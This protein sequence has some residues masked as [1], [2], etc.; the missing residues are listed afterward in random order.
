MKS[1]MDRD[2]YARIE[3]MYWRD[4][5]RHGVVLINVFMESSDA[6]ALIDGKVRRTCKCV[7]DDGSGCL[8]GRS[9]GIW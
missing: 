8:G 6:W 5:E 7:G 3:N 1:G 4:I 9:S 2:T